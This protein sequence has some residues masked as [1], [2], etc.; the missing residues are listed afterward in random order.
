M[1][2]QQSTPTPEDDKAWHV[3]H[4]K[5]HCTHNMRGQKTIQNTWFRE[6]ENK[7]SMYNSRKTCSC[8]GAPCLLVLRH[9]FSAGHVDSVLCGDGPAMIWPWLGSGTLQCCMCF[10][11]LWGSFGQSSNSINMYNMQL[12]TCFYIHLQYDVPSCQTCH[13][14]SSQ[15][16]V[17]VLRTYFV[18]GATSS[19]S[20]HLGFFSGWT[21]SD[22]TATAVYHR[23]LDIRYIENV[24]FPC[25]Q[26]MISLFIL[27]SDSW[28]LFRH[29]FISINFIF[30][31]VLILY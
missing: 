23:V 9:A 7:K 3:L 18:F 31:L 8:E 30:I 11:V 24:W 5:M 22:S 20:Q 14:L 1:D 6:G 16:V 2:F 25:D 15:G 28:Y 17:C 19:V 12:S 27:I 29:Q 4:V 26:F 21:F 10:A 13:A